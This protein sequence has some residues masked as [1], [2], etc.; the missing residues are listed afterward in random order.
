MAAPKIA[1]DIRDYLVNTALI[2]PVTIDGL[3]ASPINQYAVVEYSGPAN[4]K[5]H[6]GA[7]PGGIVL[8][9]GLLQI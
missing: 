1:V 4:I 9:R 7:N 8:D 5:T 2:T 3:A 6:G